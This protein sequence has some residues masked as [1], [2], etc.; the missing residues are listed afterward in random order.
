MYFPFNYE[1][2]N[3]IEGTYTPSVIKP[4]DNRAFDYW[5]RAFFQRAQSVLDITLPEAWSGKTRDFFNYCLFR[6]GFL[7]IFD[8]PTYG[9]TFQPCTL[10]GKD[11]YYQPTDV[12]ITNP[13]E[14]RSLQLSLGKDA[15]LLKLTPDYMGI[16]DIV[17]YYAE[18]MAILDNAINMSLINS[19]FAFILA[20]RNKAAAQAL[21]KALDKVN[22]G[23]PA[24]I[25]DM[26]LLNDPDDKDVPFQSWERKDLK[27]SYLTT[28]QLN[29]FRTIIN[30]FDREIGI[31]VSPIQKRERLTSTEA[32][33]SI[34]DS[35][36]RSLVWFNTLESSI[37]EVKKLYPRLDLSVKLHY[38]EEGAADDGKRNADDDWSL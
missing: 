6:F 34:V 38:Y 22:K 11:W 12:T 29:D 13:A 27:S 31:P 32:D 7:A 18:K 10:Y 30:D 14:E 24:V 1:T 25:L 26:K 36:A 4:Y 21:K 19:K 3:A 17:M 20:A 28:D 9:M 33:T 35:K 15:E 37:K 23:E 5:C 2:L 16:F 8:S